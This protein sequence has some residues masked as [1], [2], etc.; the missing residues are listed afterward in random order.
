M[1]E[2]KFINKNT[3][4]T[5]VCMTDT[6][7]SIVTI[8]SDN[9]LLL[10]A[11]REFTPKST[12]GLPE[13]LI[14]DAK[15]FHLIGQSCQLIL[16]PSQYQLVMMDALDV[17]EKDMAKALK[18]RLKGLID[19]PLN[20]IAIDAFMVPPHGVALQQKKAFVAV[21]VLSKL[22]AK[23]ALFES[24]Y[25]DV[26]GVSIAEL[27]IQKV[28]ALMPL[29]HQAPIILINLDDKGAQL[30]VFY[31]HNLYLVRPLHLPADL[32]KESPEHYHHTLLEIQRS[33]D[34]CLLTLKLPE[35]Q[36]IFLSPGFE[37]A[38]PLMN[39]LSQEQSKP[40]QLV[41]LNALL[42]L[43]TPLAGKLQQALFYSV[44][45]ALRMSV[46]PN[47]FDHSEELIS[48]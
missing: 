26:S 1:F 29:K 41:D 48:S 19:Y 32:S 15:Q 10:Q 23:L 7:Y 28:C 42:H 11:Y 8:G 33:I 31:N 3:A 47:P 21:T 43:S 5:A 12:P 22:R 27:A 4:Q 24:A 16:T 17:P 34:Y 36:A 25:L 46:T 13:S 18:W 38:Q 9:T 45:G 14:A 35:P 40:I 44:G 37:D 2:F 30:L 39:Y 6:S 20:D